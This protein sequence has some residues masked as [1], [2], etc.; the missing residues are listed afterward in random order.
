MK[1]E[2]SQKTFFNLALNWR[3]KIESS[4]K[5][6]SD[7]ALDWSLTN[8]KNLW[9][10]ESKPFYLKPRPGS[11]IFLKIFNQGLDLRMFLRIFNLQSRAGSKKVF[12]TSS[13]F[14]LQSTSLDWRSFFRFFHLQSGQG[15]ARYWLMCVCVLCLQLFWCIDLHIL[16]ISTIYGTPSKPQT[17]WWTLFTLILTPK[18]L[19]YIGGCSYQRKSF[20]LQRLRSFLWNQKCPLKAEVAV[21]KKL[22]EQKGQLLFQ[23]KNFLLWKGQSF[24][25]FILFFSSKRKLLEEGSYFSKRSVSLE[26]CMFISRT[27]FFAKEIDI[28]KETS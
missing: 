9:I 21:D 17:K 20:F 8:F 14:N 13:I 10:K 25:N 7:P 27:I 5:T 28:S 24:K 6:F 11:K 18:I 19:E 12:W 3:L 2:E 15:P 1:I 26:K 23:K 4:Q 16:N 22:S